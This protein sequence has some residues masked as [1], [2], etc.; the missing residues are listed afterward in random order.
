MLEIIA[1]LPLNT[2]PGGGTKMFVITNYFVRYSQSCWRRYNSGCTKGKTTS[3]VGM[4][5]ETTL[6]E[7]ATEVLQLDRVSLRQQLTLLGH[8]VLLIYA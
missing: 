3:F 2:K 7:G 1:C 6:Q 8:T 5:F 4:N